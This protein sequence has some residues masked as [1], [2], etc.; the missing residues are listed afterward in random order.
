[1]FQNQDIIICLLSTFQLREEVLL[2]KERL[3]LME[4]FLLKV[5]E[6]YLFQGFGE[7]KLK[8]DKIYTV[9]ILDLHRLKNQDGLNTMQKIQSA[10]LL[11]IS[12]FTLRKEKIH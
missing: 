6:T 2:L 10:M 12:I 3:K 9:M 8:L 1:M 7:M 11:V 4:K 5:L